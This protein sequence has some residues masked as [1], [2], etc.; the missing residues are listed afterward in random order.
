MPD[1]YDEGGGGEGKKSD[2]RIE[3]G[4]RVR[5]TSVSIIMFTFK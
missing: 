1:S 3:F 2:V 4:N 5:F